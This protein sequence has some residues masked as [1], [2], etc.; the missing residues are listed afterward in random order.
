MGAP[1]KS[2]CID[3]EAVWH[4]L[5]A[6]DVNQHPPFAQLAI[7]AAPVVSIDAAAY[8]IR[9][10]Q[11]GAVGREGKTVRE[12]NTVRGYPDRTIGVYA[13]QK[14]GPALA[15]FV[16]KLRAGINAPFRIGNTIVQDTF[17]PISVCGKQDWIRSHT[18]QPHSLSV[19]YDQAPIVL[20]GKPGDFK[21]LLQAFV[22]LILPVETEKS[23]ACD[24]SPVKNFFL[25]N[26]EG[27]FSAQIA[28]VGDDSNLLACFQS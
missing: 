25:R 23:L 7:F 26:P 28:A 22:P 24:V 2:F 8:R 9:K 17:L 14:A 21:S 4:A 6:R 1:E 16:E 20:K 27:A 13:K 15:L 5:F 18:P 19:G 11:G 3:S 10:V 12:L